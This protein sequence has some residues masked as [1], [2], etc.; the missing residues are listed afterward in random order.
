MTREKVLVGLSGGVGSAVVAS[1]LKT[2]GYEVH[3]AHFTFRPKNAV[4]FECAESNDVDRA[5]AVAKKL[6]IPITVT[7]L[8]DL[9]ED[10]VIDRAMQSWVVYK[11]PNPCHACHSKIKVEP[12]VQLAREGGYAKVATGHYAQILTDPARKKPGLYRAVDGGFDQSYFLSELTSESLSMMI[13]PL[14]GL[15]H[16]I[17]TKMASQMGLEPGED[18]RKMC[19]LSH[20]GRKEY[21]ASRVEPHF[22]QPG[23][24]I[25]Q[26][27]Q[28]I[29]RHE[30]IAEFEI[31]KPDSLEVTTPTIE[32]T[33][34]QV[35]VTLNYDRQKNAVIAGTLDQ[36][37]SRK[38]LGVMARWLVK[39]QGVKVLKENSFLALHRPFQDPT[40]CKVIL[41]ENQTLEISFDEPEAHLVAGQKIVFLDR[42][43]IVGSAWIEK[44]LE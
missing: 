1:L 7:D 38:A 10:I 41:F 20:P 36:I 35:Y 11:T 28:T 25:L 17:V 16:N 22:R 43:E 13:M 30:G 37:F 34:K 42:D 32:G 31:G 24:V 21:Y 4:P 19:L 6:G 14:G 8:R 27:G 3:A 23:P 29:G 12:L 44:V 26:D 39:P 33:N 2:Q 40:P 5:K 15:S 18:S 9:F